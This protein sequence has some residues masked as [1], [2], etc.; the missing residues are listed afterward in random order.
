MVLSLPLFFLNVPDAHGLGDDFA[1][2]IKEAQNISHGQPYYKSNYIYND[3]D[4]EYAPP[5]Y[6]VGYPILLA[7]VVSMFGIAIRPML[8][9]NCIIF[10]G[11]LL[12]L[13][14][15]FRRYANTVIAI[16][17]SLIIVYSNTMLDAKGN[18]LSDV[19]FMLFV[20][21]Y[22]LL[23]NS[24]S[25]SKG[26][27]LL[28]IC[29]A[30]MAILTRSQGIILLAAEGILFMADC[31][32]WIR[33]RQFTIRQILNHVSV[34]VTIGTIV[35]FVVVNNIIFSTPVGTFGY[36]VTMSTHRTVGFRDLLRTNWDY[37]NTL[38]CELVHIP[39]SGPW[40]QRFTTLVEY[41]VYIS[42]ALGL[43][44]SLIKKVR[45]DDLVFLMGC[46]MVLFVPVHQG[47][48]ILFAIFPVYILYSY[49]SV[50]R[51]AHI[52]FKFRLVAAGVVMTVLYLAAGYDTYRKYNRNE[53]NGCVPGP[54]PS[55]MFAQVRQTM[56][57]SDV[58]V[59]LKPRL[60][61]LYTGKKAVVYAY[62]ETPENNRRKFDDLKV[63]YIL[64]WFDE[65]IM[66]F[67]RDNYKIID[68]V[69]AGD[70]Y[71]YRVR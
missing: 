37:L 6:P 55:A 10:T 16:C 27:V 5:Q 18:I 45:V 41:S 24:E 33:A 62:K 70:T 25:Y 2:Y 47:V 34:Q 23:R 7:P 48:R 21:L 56:H 15:Y 28:L 42:A 51:I 11:L 8:Y 49:T 71:L 12:A 38:F 35:L 61:T 17:L 31:V 3:I 53:C 39:A 29:T 58:V 4:K 9:L 67:M 22:L 13:Y 57:D 65:T 40:S 14:A 20:L 64:P 52:V 59:F 69:G 32:R 54:M 30:V 60:L 46:L 44:M 68:S 43:V 26:R 19:P 50:S 1:Q 66:R 63:S 36:Y